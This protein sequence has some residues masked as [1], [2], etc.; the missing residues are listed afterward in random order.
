MDFEKALNRIASENQS[1]TVAMIAVDPRA[2]EGYTDAASRFMEK[3]DVS[4]FFP[5][6][7]EGRH[8]EV[9]DFVYVPSATRNHCLKSP[10]DSV[11]IE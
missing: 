7:F 8:D 9:C 6:H 3:I 10:G 2:G 4:H 5:M 11:M 1:V